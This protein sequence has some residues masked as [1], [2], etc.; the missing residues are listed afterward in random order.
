[1]SH[2]PI[3]FFLIGGWLILHILDRATKTSP[4]IKRELLLLS[5]ISLFVLIDSMGDILLMIGIVPESLV[6]CCTTVIDILDRPTRTTPE[7]IFGP[8]YAQSLQVLFFIT[9]LALL[10]FIGVSL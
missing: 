4:L 1:M 6:S 3:T 7:S 5:V 9:H 8:E 10:G 2:P